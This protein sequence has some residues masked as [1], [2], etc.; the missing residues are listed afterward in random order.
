MDLKALDLFLKNIYTKTDSLRRARILTQVLDQK[1]FNSS[2]DIAKQL[3]QDDLEWLNGL[4]KEFLESFNKQN[5]ASQ[6]NWLKDSINQINYLTLYIPFEMPLEEKK[7][8]GQ[9]L[10]STYGPRFLFEIKL[11]PLLI[12]GCA[13]VWKGIYRDYSLKNRIEQ[14]KQPILSILKEY[15]K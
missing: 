1:L 7:N 15:I 2:E 10:R 3:N 5:L 14:Q 11:N 8:I 12:G 6:L 9:K 13:L 4:D